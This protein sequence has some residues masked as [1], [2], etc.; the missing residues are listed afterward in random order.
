[1]KIFRLISLI[2][3]VGC[4]L[5]TGCIGQIKNTPANGTVTPTNTFTPF[6]NETNISNT[7]N[8]TVTPGFNGSLRVSIGGWDADLP[9]YI[10]N[11]SAGIVTH[12]KPL[13]L[14]LPEGNHTVKVCTS[15]ICEQQNVTIR[16]AKL[17]VVDF[18]EQL[19]KDVGFPNPTAR[20][21]GSY[22]SSDRIT[23]T[24]EFINPSAKDLSMSAIVKCAY[25]YIE[26]RS[27]NRVGGLAQGVANANVKSG[28]RVM[29]DVNLYLSSGYS[30]D[31]DIP[32]ISSITTR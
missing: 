27:N 6:L 8:S 16:F 9:V 3:I 32:T 11:K 31:Y 10:D 25:T 29:Q 22:P 30:Y 17:Q 1:M 7:T 12:S 24:V 28:N 23:V 13:E 26:P 5:A 4:I 15:L 21:V 2:I 14:M 19:L 18:E 20:I